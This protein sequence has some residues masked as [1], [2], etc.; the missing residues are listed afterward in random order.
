MSSGAL[1]SRDTVPEGH[2]SSAECDRIAAAAARLSGGYRIQ[3]GPGNGSHAWC[4]AVPGPACGGP[5]FS[6][7]RFGPAVML[8]TKQR[9]GPKTVVPSSSL[10]K[11]IEAME[12]AAS[13]QIGGISPFLH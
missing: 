4:S 1:E 2:L 11:A 6:F 9:E 13:G 3:V 10:Q 8:L 12:A 7:C 5:T